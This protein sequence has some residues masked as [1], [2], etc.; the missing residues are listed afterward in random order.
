MCIDIIDC[1]YKIRIVFDV[2]NIN[3]LGKGNGKFF[4][5]WRILVEGYMGEVWCWV[6]CLNF[7]MEVFF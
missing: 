2:W 4:C 5:I 7:G 6:S 1:G 3:F